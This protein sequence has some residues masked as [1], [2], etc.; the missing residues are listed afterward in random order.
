MADAMCAGGDAVHDSTTMALPTRRAAYCDHIPA[1]PGNCREWIVAARQE[2]EDI[3]ELE[4][5]SSERRR[6]QVPPARSRPRHFCRAW[7]RTSMVQVRRADDLQVFH[8]RRIVEQVSRTP[9]RWCTQS[10][11]DTRV[12]RSS[13]MK[14]AQPL[15]HEDDLEVRLMAAK[16]ARA[17]LRVRCAR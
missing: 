9:G 17:F 6:A 15:Q 4:M 3:D 1:L 13:C 2:P 10:P 16:R 14:R 11:A 8:V 12:S 5:Q 7:G